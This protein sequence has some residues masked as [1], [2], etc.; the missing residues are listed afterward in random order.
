ML[1]WVPLV[2]PRRIPTV[3]GRVGIRCQ[4]R[5]SRAAASCALPRIVG[6]LRGEVGEGGFV[7]A[8]NDVERVSSPE[9]KSPTDRRPNKSFGG[10]ACAA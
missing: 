1:V 6:S 4:Q 8:D 5:T 7:G 2:F 9:K 10:T 3:P